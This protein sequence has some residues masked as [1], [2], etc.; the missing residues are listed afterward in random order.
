MTPIPGD[1]AKR[2]E[3]EI[4]Q[5]SVFIAENPNV[6]AS[7][8]KQGAELVGPTCRSSLFYYI[9]DA[10]A[11]QWIVKTGNTRGTRYSPTDQFSHHLAMANLALP[12]SKR[13]K[14]GYNEDFLRCYI[15]NETY[16]LSEKQRSQLHQC[17]SRGAFDASDA[18]SRMRCAVLW[19]TSAI[20]RPRLKE[21]MS[22]SLTPSASWSRTSIRAT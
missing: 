2:R 7:A 18:R 21:L 20:T 13:A 11:N 1:N 19:P 16:Y 14:V 5:L 10:I 22:S 15:P 9:N 6:S 17:C 3:R 4:Y 12:K 8:V